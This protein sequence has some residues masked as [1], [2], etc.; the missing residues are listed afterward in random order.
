MEIIYLSCFV[1]QE[2]FIFSAAFRGCMLVV[3]A[4]RQL[5]LRLAAKKN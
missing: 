4:S 5:D 1:F 3:S 2:I